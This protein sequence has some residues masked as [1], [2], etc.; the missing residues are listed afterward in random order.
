MFQSDLAFVEWFL[1]EFRDTASVTHLLGSRLTMTLL[2]GGSIGLCS[3]GALIKEFSDAMHEGGLDQL[4]YWSPNASRES[5]DD[6]IEAIAPTRRVFFGRHI[7]RYSLSSFKMIGY[8]VT[9]NGNVINQF[10]L[11]EGV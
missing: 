5:V 8:V 2:P 3:N 10:S 9:M 6:Y 1:R 4:G 7:K 11:E